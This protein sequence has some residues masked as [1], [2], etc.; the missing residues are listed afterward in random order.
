[1]L[2]RHHAPHWPASQHSQVRVVPSPVVIECEKTMTYN[3]RWPILALADCGWLSQKTTDAGNDERRRQRQRRGRL[4]AMLLKP[5]QWVETW[6]EMNRSQRSST[7]T[8]TTHQPIHAAAGSLTAGWIRLVRGGF[9]SGNGW[10]AS[11]QMRTSLRTSAACVR[12]VWFFRG[13]SRRSTT[14]HGHISLAYCS[15]WKSRRN[16][17][18]MG[19]SSYEDRD[20]RAW[21]IWW[22]FIWR[23]W[24]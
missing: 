19:P 11:M 3:V 14:S 1:M 21:P 12:L 4:S 20:W 5:K 7:R 8:R 23:V 24:W 16:E 18:E 6:E 22:L 9:P 10:D 2:H 15:V 17:R 13:W